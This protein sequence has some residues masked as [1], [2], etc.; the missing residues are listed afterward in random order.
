MGLTQQDQVVEIGRPAVGPE[1]D[2]VRLQPPPLPAAGELTAPVPDPQRASLGG[3]GQP[4]RPA[5]RQYVTFGVT[6][7]PDDI[8]VT[9]VAGCGGRFDRATTLDPCL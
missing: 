2:V 5:H 8:P 9:G 4:P 6:D 3:G 1:D 7:H